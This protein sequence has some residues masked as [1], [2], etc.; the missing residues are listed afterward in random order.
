MAIARADRPRV[1]VTHRST[2]KV[3]QSIDEGLHAI[4]FSLQD[5]ST[6]DNLPES[7][8]TVIITFELS[9]AAD[10]ECLP[11][12]YKRLTSGNEKLK[13][14]QPQVVALSTTS[15]FSD[16]GVM[17]SVVDEDSPLTGVGV[18]GKPMDDRIQAEQYLIGQGCTV[19]ALSGL[20]GPG[21]DAANFMNWRPNGLALVNLIHLDDACAAIRLVSAGAAAGRRIIV[22]SGA[23]KYNH[24]AEPLGLEPLAEAPDQLD[25]KKTKRVCAAVLVGLLPQD[26][27]FVLPVPG[28]PPVVLAS[29][30]SNL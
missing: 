13:K 5:E 20:V 8:A 21:R 14:L 25:A 6:W 11:R 24:W 7:F 10:S 9:W 26:Y 16:G 23:Y 18:M 28:V 17:H 1:I 12:L 29:G 27:Q 15:V 4:Q 2:E 19:L 22:S 30:T 3:K